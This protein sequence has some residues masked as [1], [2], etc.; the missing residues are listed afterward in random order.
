[1]I[2]M[3]KTKKPKKGKKGKKDEMP[4]GPDGKP[5]DCK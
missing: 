2:Q 4:L 3:E 5:Q 1:M